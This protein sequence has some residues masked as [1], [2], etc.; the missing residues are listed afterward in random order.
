MDV[1]LVLLT[2][3]TSINK[4]LDEGGKPRPPVV[5]FEDRLGAKDAHMAREGGGVYGM[6]ECRLGG[7]GNKH[8]TFK[9]QMTI[10]I[11]PVR[12]SGVREKG[13]TIL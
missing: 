4:V 5:P 2:D 7:W 8:P 3:R 13:G 11:V 9:V 12:E 1:D 10:V 6:Q